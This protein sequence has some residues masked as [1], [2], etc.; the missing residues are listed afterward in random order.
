M[1]KKK[2]PDYKI[3]ASSARFRV[4]NK[5]SSDLIKV[6]LK[7]KRKDFRS[8]RYINKEHLDQEDRVE[9]AKVDMIHQYAVDT[10]PPLGIQR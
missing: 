7:D 10:C 5:G 1:A 4:V 8:V 2:D 3:L 9:E 6:I